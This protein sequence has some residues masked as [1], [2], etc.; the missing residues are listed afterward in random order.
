MSNQPTIRITI[1]YTRDGQL[2]YS[3]PTD[4]V[5]ALGMLELAKT[6]IANQST[7]PQKL[8]QPVAVVPPVIASK[9]V[10]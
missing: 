8:V 9:K 2:T 10:G 6:T 4:K 1:E 5:L 7:E 3:G